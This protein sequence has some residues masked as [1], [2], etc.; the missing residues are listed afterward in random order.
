MARHRNSVQKGVENRFQ[1]EWQ[2]LAIPVR[3]E[4]EECYVRPLQK[5][6]RMLWETLDAMAT[7]TIKATLSK[8]IVVGGEVCERRF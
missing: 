7:E 1:L 5:D 6:T 8:S 2:P 4:K 3:T